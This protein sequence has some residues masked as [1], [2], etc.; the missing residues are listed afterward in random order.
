MK[1]EFF[2]A[3]HYLLSKKTTNVINLISF[4]SVVGIAFGTAALLIILSIFNGLEDL[5][6]SRYNSFDP[7]Y[8][9]LPKVGKTFSFD[10]VKYDKLLNISDIKCVVSVIEENVLVKYGKVYN[11]ARIKGV[12][13]NFSCLNGIDTMITAGEYS[14]N[15]NGYPVAVVGQSIASAL[16]LQLNFIMPIVIYEP[17]RTK[18]VIVNPEKAFVKKPIYVSGIFSIEPNID[19]YIIVPFDFAN[20]LLHYEN[21]VTSL[22]ISV[23]ESGNGRDLR[24]KIMDAIGEDVI[25]KDRFEQHEFTYKILK[26][27]K[28]ITYFILT[29]IIIIASFTLIG[30]LSMLIIEKK[31]DIRT[32]YSLGM[33]TTNIKNIF[34]LVG[35]F[36]AFIGSSFGLILGAGFVYVQEKFGLIK[37]YGA[38]NGNFIVDA[39]PVRLDFF[40]VVLVFVTVISIG[41]LA[42]KY[43]LRF[44]VRKYF[45]DKTNY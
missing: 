14:L 27:E 13:E 5:I 1:L 34:F 19:N 8:K 16:S 41:I 25:I 30:S 33:T 38:E 11:P 35:L 29:L 3:R 18:K 32:F 4:I 31:N 43:P 15:I 21:E 10:S 2:I 40:D 17:K 22:E 6:I 20:E 28:M 45:V 23:N 42:S 39:Y 7:D 36:I 37:L 24:K 9:V 26:S 12:T 44:V